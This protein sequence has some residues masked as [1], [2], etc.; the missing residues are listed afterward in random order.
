MI[1]GEHFVFRA[2]DGSHRQL[3]V[4][5]EV[6]EAGEEFERSF[7]GDYSRWLEHEIGSHDDLALFDIDA[8]ARE[9]DRDLEERRPWWFEVQA[10]H[11]RTAELEAALQEAAG[12]EIPAGR[13]ALEL[14][15]E[16]EPERDELVPGL[17]VKGGVTLIG[18]REKLSGK[19]TLI[20]YLASAMERQ[21][22]TVFGD[23]YRKP[24]QTLVLTEEP[25][26][27]VR[28]KVERFNLRDSRVVYGWEFEPASEDADKRWKERIGHA[29]A[30]AKEGGFEHVVIDPFSRMAEIEN[31]AGREP[32]ERA[33]ALSFHAQR[34]DLAVT[35]VHHNNKSGGRLEDLFRGSTSL[36]A[37][38]EQMVQV[39]YKEKADRRRDLASWARVET[40]SW[41][42]TIELSE[43][44]TTYAGVEKADAEHEQRS[45]A[46]AIAGTVEGERDIKTA[47][48]AAGLNK[49][50]TSKTFKAALGRAQRDGTVVKLRQGHYGDPAMQEDA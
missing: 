50:P 4:P 22:A 35:L 45:L 1:G 5:A 3:H 34:L 18:G 41:E 36:P 24:V 21:E 13:T 37:A 23:P 27:A 42:R 11:D 20:F 10:H 15:A 19:S 25:P 48:I 12:R 44:G 16:V 38:V 40:G 8:L 32:G 26:Y 9:L 7:G 2:K 6:W 47:D 14:L 39:G 29:C 17:I 28:D 49:Q 46:A 33:E 43:D 30:V 31:E